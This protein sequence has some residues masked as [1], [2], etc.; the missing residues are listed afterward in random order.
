MFFLPGL[1]FLLINP[2]KFFSIENY[3]ISE[4]LQK[5]FK[6]LRLWESEINIMD[7]NKFKE[8]L[9]IVKKAGELSE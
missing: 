3:K 8:K 1:V 7:I 2:P 5:G 4:L 6:I 9:N